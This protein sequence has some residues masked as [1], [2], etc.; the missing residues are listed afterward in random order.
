M[1]RAAKMA[2]RRLVATLT[3]WAD[4]E[5]GRFILLVPCLM[6]AGVATWLSADRPPGL[7]VLLPVTAIWIALFVLFFRRRQDAWMLAV[8]PLAVFFLGM[9]LIALR[10]AWVGAPAV[11]DGFGS[12]TVTGVLERV[13]DR[14]KDHRY[15]VR[16]QE[17]SR[18][19]DAIPRRVRV[20]WRGEP[21]NA[22][23]GDL[24]RMRVSLSPPPGPATPG[25]YDFAQ[26]M[27]YERIGGVGF[28]Y[29]PPAVI[30]RG[31]RG[32]ATRVER[33]REGIAG[34]IEGHIDGPPGAV[35]AALVTGKRERIPQGTV[36]DLRD[37][38]LAHLLAI[39][40][41]H[42]GLVCGFLFFTLRWVLAQSE[43]LA[44]RYPIKKWAALGALM[45]GS[46]YLILSGAAW[47]AQRAFIMA[48]IVF[49]A[50][51]FDRRGISL[52]NAAIAAIVIVLIR[53]EAVISAG[54][55]MSFAAVV[56]LI[57]AFSFLEERFPRSEDRSA[58]TRVTGFI[59]GLAMTSIIAGLATAPFALFHFGQVATY[60]LLGNLLAMPIITLGVMPAAVLALF[61]MPLGLDG[62]IFVLVGRGI[63]LV[64]RIAH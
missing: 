63:D 5:E 64:L 47:S 17:L 39:S 61:V 62:L 40:G 1:P 49:L 59:G 46:F 24:I 35:A 26:A 10:T 45:G 15:T 54:F 2:A 58:F 51:L 38:G 41:L 42:M 14:K 55:Q 3:A 22:K 34:R 37:A 36:D 28:S 8:R 16:V 6:A 13:E 30:E 52:R 18:F 56:S 23:A 48:S 7:F 60:G 20:V 33:L 50:I 9:T 43:T 32:W 25:G 57:A 21:G 44:L 4:Q 19:G 31:G 29:A 27:F 11:P 53:P 12:A